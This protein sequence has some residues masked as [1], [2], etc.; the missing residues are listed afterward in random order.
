MSTERVQYL[1]GLKDQ[2]SA[3]LDGI[4]NKAI[5]TENQLKK[6]GTGAQKMGGG[7]SGM[8][9]GI[10]SKIAGLGLIAGAGMVGKSIV[11]M[12][13]N[14]EMTRVSFETFLGSAEK[15]NKV[16]ADLNQFAN[17]TPF[18]NEQ[19]IS[20]GRSLL[21]FGSTSEELIPTL[22][23]IG[24]ISSAVGKDFNELTTIYGKAQTAGVL[25][26]EDINQLTEAGIPVIDEF[27]KILKT[28]PDNVKKM[29]SEGKVTF[30]VLQKAFVNLTKEGGRFGGL[31]DKQSKTLSGVWSSLTGALQLYGSQI[32]EAIAPHLKTVI[33]SIGGE[34]GFINWIKTNFEQLKNVFAPLKSLIEPIVNTFK[35]LSEKIE[36]MTGGASILESIFTGIGNVLLFL[37]PVFSAVGDLFSS[38]V[39]KI[40]DVGVAF[41]NF[42]KTSTI[43]QTYLKGTVSAIV[44]I[45]VGLKE[46]IKSTLTGVGDILIG[47]FT[48]DAGK[49][50]SGMKSM[51][52]AMFTGIG[53]GVEAGKKTFNTEIKDFGFSAVPDAQKPTGTGKTLNDFVRKDKPKGDAKGTKKASSSVDGISGGRPTNIVI[54]ITKLIETFNVEN[55]N[56]KMTEN[57]IRGLVSRALISSVN[58]VN[59]IAR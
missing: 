55:N 12:G 50:A 31:M 48:L 28:T 57:E 13:A 36:K 8:F 1:I 59:N 10:G 41:Y 42:I 18:D 17:A 24:D 53:A 11:S 27:A 38:I 37:E 40:F 5:K 15:G 47:I 45:F 25:M 6:T 4:T 30:S 44:G 35:S 58:D 56:M 21:A 34:K 39:E 20:A 33:D 26:A 49:I 9:A 43:M 7:V 3:G 2:I 19:V 29:G 51:S 54:N 14:M 16:I 32:G 46:S 52:T 22:T 23:A